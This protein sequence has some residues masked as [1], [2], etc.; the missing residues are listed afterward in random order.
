[1]GVLG[2]EC[3]NSGMRWCGP[4]VENFWG[5]TEDRRRIGTIF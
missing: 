1:M 3:G 5:K 4:R 2:G